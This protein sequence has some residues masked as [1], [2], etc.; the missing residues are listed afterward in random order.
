MTIL[1]TQATYL[2][3]QIIIKHD[4]DI[5]WQKHSAMLILWA[6]ILLYP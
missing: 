5:L 2:Y 4:R 3:I 1:Q 6:K